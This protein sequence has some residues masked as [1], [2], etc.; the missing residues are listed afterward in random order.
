MQT[1]NTYVENE[2]TYWRMRNRLL[3]KHKG[4]FVL[5]CGSRYFVN[6][7]RQSIL[8]ASQEHP[9]GF[10]AHLGYEDPQPGDHIP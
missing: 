3:E 7:D 5:V 4:S 10:F 9:N 2:A 6:S 8:R 1:E